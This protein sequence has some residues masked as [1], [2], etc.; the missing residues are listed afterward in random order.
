MAAPESAAPGGRIDLK[1]R[2][3]AC[4]REKTTVLLGLAVGICIP[5]FVLQRVSGVSPFEVPMTDA[6]WEI[7]FGPDWII[8]YLS[9]ALLVPLG[10]L[11]ARSREP[12]ERY[13]TGLAILCAVCFAL[14]WL[15]PVEGPR[16][17][18]MPAQPI[19]QLLVSWDRPTNSLPSLHAG[20]VVYSLLF[21]DR[22]VT[23]ELGHRRRM[24][25]NALGWSWGAL[26]LYSTLA[27]KQHW[28]LDLPAGMGVAAAAHWIAWRSADSGAGDPRVP[29]A[30]G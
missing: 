15:F 23:R 10:P 27:T 22:V 28:F 19:Y 18:E 8:V 16:P 29:L 26:I 21:I 4:R 30:T 24:L 13:A 17:D 3:L 1:S 12:L 5:Y 7:P 14:F 6:D 25:W 2:L 11:L 20:L 9:I